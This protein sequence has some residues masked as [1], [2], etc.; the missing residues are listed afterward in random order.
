[1]TYILYQ[2]SQHA[3][4]DCPNKTNVMII[5]RGKSITPGGYFLYLYTGVC[6]WRVKF[7]PQNMDSL[8]NNNNN[9]NNNTMFIQG[10]N[11]PYKGMTVG[12]VVS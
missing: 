7:K 11:K 6:V 1:M 10:T 9:N 4:F 3:A 12:P 2:R 8:Y 5:T